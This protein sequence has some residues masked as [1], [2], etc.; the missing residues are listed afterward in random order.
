MYKANLQY[1]ILQISYTCPVLRV[2][3]SYANHSTQS[4]SRNFNIIQ[5]LKI[6]VEKGWHNSCHI[7]NKYNMY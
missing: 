6:Y 4:L 2:P 7:K 5:T 1:I 3:I